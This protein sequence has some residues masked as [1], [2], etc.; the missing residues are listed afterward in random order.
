MSLYPV[1]HVASSDW[2]LLPTSWALQPTKP[3]VICVIA[4]LHRTPHSRQRLL[5]SAHIEQQPPRSP[6]LPSRTTSLLFCALSHPHMNRSASHR[7]GQLWSRSRPSPG[8]LLFPEHFQS[9]RH[10]MHARRFGAPFSQLHMQSPGAHEGDTGAI[11]P[12]AVHRNSSSGDLKSCQGVVPTVI[13]AQAA[14]AGSQP[15]SAAALPHFQTSI[16]NNS[17]TQNPFLACPGTRQALCCCVPLH[18]CTHSLSH[19]RRQPL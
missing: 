7:H 19:G 16:N 1:A 6:P 15:P 14:A 17:E 18:C 12:G 11:C 5:L 9:W 4:Q 10:G 2:S 13:T 3:D 8:E